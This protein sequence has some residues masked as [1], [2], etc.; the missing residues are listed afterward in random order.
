MH[1]SVW[2]HLQFSVTDEYEFFSSC[3]PVS[4][5]QP[6][7]RGSVAVFSRP[8]SRA[9]ASLRRTLRRSVICAKIVGMEYS[10]VGKFHMQNN[11]WGAAGRGGG[12]RVA[13]RSAKVFQ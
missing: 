3:V 10:H 9:C 13:A 4:Q 5:V 7:E 6:G 8:I 2:S 1:A 11:P 12:G